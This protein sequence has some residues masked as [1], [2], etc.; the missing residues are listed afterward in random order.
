MSNRFHVASNQKTKKLGV[1]W[2]IWALAA[3]FYFSD[4]MARV[5]VSVMHRY[6]Q[7]D[8]NMNEAQFGILSASFYVP[9]ILMQ[10]PV[11]LMIDRLNIRWVLTV[12]SLLTAF[13]CCVFGL[14]DSLMMAAVGRMLIGFTAAFAFIS[15]LR[16]A[17]SWFPP[18]MMGLLAGLTQAVG[19][20]GAAS[21]QAPVAFL[22]AGIGWRHSM[23]VI[24]FVFIVLAV[25]LYQYVR[26][27]PKAQSCAV[28]T[29]KDKKMGILESLRIVLSMPQ[30]WINALFTGF[31][32]APT[33]VIGESLGAAY[34]QYG[35]HLQAHAAAFITGLIF[36]GWTVGGPFA[37]WLSDRLGRRKP[38]M[39]FSAVCGIILS[40]MMV[41]LPGMGK[42]LASILFFLFGFTNVG[43]SIAYAVST[44]LHH[45]AVVGTA[46]AFT[47]MASIFVGALLQPVVGRLIDHIAGERAY[48]VEHLILPDFQYGLWVLP[49]CSFIALILAFMVKETYCN[50]LKNET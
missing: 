5:A 21:G 34:L 35:R 25:F 9:Y 8:F 1:A 46:I 37:G 39:I 30:T 47:N 44:E 20:L 28:K 18:S 15:T 26:D 33:A 2:L 27:S 50:P 4:Y 23:L 38:V 42:V 45:R 22:V 48:N 36:I 10:I 13:A 24:A 19:M 12:M 31:V 43:V 3:A 32:F 40:S 11:G 6:L 14:A 49:I 16:L 29:S 41:F 17:T 7:V